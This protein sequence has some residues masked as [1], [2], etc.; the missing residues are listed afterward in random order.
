M[1]EGEFYNLAKWITQ[2]G[3]A[4]LDEPATLTGFCERA[5]ATGIPLARVNIVIDTLHPIYQGRAFTWKRH[6][7]ETALTEY[8]RSNDQL[9]R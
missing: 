2:A 1:N 6:A 5:V 7:R 4:G 9:D 3:L 8:G